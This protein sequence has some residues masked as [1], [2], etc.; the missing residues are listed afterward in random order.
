MLKSFY[1]K[2]FSL[3]C[4]KS[5]T[6]RW[7]LRVQVFLQRNL[8]QLFVCSYE[9]NDL[10]NSAWSNWFYL[11][12][13]FQ[14]QLFCIINFQV[15]HLHLM[16]FRSIQGFWNFFCFLPLLKINGWSVIKKFYRCRFF[17]GGGFLLI[18]ASLVGKGGMGLYKAVKAGNAF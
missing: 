1:W 9:R 18:T 15:L 17:I 5:A 6:L 11:Q 14:V 8:P 2:C 3:Q 7:Y 12:F 4:P 16:N 10:R 13:H